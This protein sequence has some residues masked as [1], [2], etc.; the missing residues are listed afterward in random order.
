MRP[1]KGRLQNRRHVL[2]FSHSDHVSIMQR[3]SEP[4]GLERSEELISRV[5]VAKLAVEAKEAKILH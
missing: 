5:T 3:L 2:G 1:L 4:G